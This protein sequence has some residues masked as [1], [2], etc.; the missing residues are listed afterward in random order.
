MMGGP[1]KAGLAQRKGKALAITSI[2]TGTADP[3]RV[4]HL[5]VLQPLPLKM[6]WR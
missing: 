1:E 2:S 4:A 3:L 5:S 6:R